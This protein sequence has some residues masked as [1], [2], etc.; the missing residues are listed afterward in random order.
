MNL[1]QTKGR[2]ADAIIAVFRASDYFGKEQEPFASA[3]RLLYVV[4]T[5]ARRQVTLLLP[6]SPHPLV[7]PL[8]SLTS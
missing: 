7:A 1:H 3:S 5:R 6:T 2:E 8:A 4:L